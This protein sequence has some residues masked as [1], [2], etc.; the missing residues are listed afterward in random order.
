MVPARVEPGPPAAP[1]AR[2]G[3]RRGGPA[4]RT[5]PPRR[6]SCFQ[7]LEHQALG[8][9]LEEVQRLFLVEEHEVR[10][11]A[12]ARRRTPEQAG[13]EPVE[14]GDGRAR[15]VGLHP[16]PLGGRRDRS[17]PGGERRAQ[18]GLGGLTGSEGCNP[19]GEPAAHLGRCLLGEGEEAEPGGW[20]GLVAVRAA[21]EPRHSVM[22]PCVFPVPAPAKTQALGRRALIPRLPGARGARRSGRPSRAGRS[23][24]RAGARGRAPGAARRAARGRRSRGS[25]RWWRTESRRRWRGSSRAGPCG[26]GSRGRNSSVRSDSHPA[27]NGGRSPRARSARR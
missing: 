2:S 27:W 15:E 19:R 24:T 3:G 8:E 9:L 4:R 21:E 23:R 10:R 26:P 13:A 12:G 20:E 5:A 17:A 1:P 7:P 14:G 25:A 11:R 6:I 22:R 18:L 16:P